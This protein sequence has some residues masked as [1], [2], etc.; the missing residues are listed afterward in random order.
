MPL[1]RELYELCMLNACV[2]T[3]CEAQRRARP[4][5]DHG[6]SGGT[7]LIPQGGSMQA[8]IARHV[9]FPLALVVCVALAG[10]K[11]K[12]TGATTDSTSAAMNTT[13]GATTGAMAG[14]TSAMGSTANTA[15]SG[16]TGAALSDAN[17][18][19]LVN[20]ANMGDS[21]LAAAALPKL[22]STG[23][24]NFAKLMMGEHHAAHVQGLQVEKAQNITP[25][26]P[27]TDPF[28]PAVEAEQSALASMPKGAAYDSTY[29]AHEV[30]IHQAVIDWAGKNTPKNAAYQ[31]YI[32]AISPTLQKH[33]NMGLALQKSMAGS[34]K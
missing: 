19:A 24:R 18:A 34:K 2:C 22:T 32:K 29:I 30:G 17:I 26:L 25:A 7:R 23:A 33:L 6:K 28:K 14:D 11:A 15:N 20:E 16:A 27:A 21:A 9:S 3:A 5:F 4:K 10:C 13:T 1:A 12:D 31:Q 8:E